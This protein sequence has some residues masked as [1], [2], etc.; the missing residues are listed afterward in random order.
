MHSVG[1]F[2]RNEKEVM[3]LMIQKDLEMKA[4]IFLVL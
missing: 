4:E 1:L 2:V 3:K